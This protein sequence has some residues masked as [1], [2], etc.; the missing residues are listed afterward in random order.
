MNDGRTQ[1]EMMYIIKKKANNTVYKNNP[2]KRGR[3]TFSKL[4]MNSRVVRFF[5]RRK[6]LYFRN[7]MRSERGRISVKSRLAQKNTSFKYNIFRFCV[8]WI[9][10]LF[11]EMD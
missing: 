11:L 9:T 8:V 4:F 10:R 6:K 3:H 5:I 1:D 7:V 2:G